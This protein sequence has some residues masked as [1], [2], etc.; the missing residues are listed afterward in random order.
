MTALYLIRHAHHLHDRVGGQGPWLDLGLS[1]LGLAQARALQSRLSMS[2]A[3]REGVLIS[4]TQRRAME[5]AAVVAQG[6]GRPFVADADFEEWRNEDGT[7]GGEEFAALWL[8]LPEQQRPFYRF[9]PGCESRIEFTTRVHI[10]LNRILLQHEGKT[11]VLI[12]H[13]GVI[14]ASFQFFF[15][16]GDASFNRAYPAFGNAS[17][18]HWRQDENAKCWVLE[19]SNDVAH[20]RANIA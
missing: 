19:S 17:V 1:G 14:E 3:L 5:T 15:G 16:Y 12:S 11:I 20:V 4:S 8:G 10:A 9:A 13:G 18:T 2:R 6:L 7:F